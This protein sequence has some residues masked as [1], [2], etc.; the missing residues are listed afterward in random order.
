MFEKVIVID[1]KGHLLGRLAAV[2]AKELLNGQKIVVVR[3]EELNI[4]G[5]LERN[6]RAYAQFV[7]RIS[8]TNPW[9]GGPWHYKNPS[10]IFWRAVRGMLPHKT[11]RGAAALTRLKIFEGIPYPYSHMKRTSVASALR[12]VRLDNLRHF[13]VLKDLSAKVGW[14]KKE[15]I[16]NLEAKRQER[17][18]KYWT[19]K[20]TI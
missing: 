12:C 7:N 16:Q 14:N 6:L 11:P 5:P 2:V 10:K 18:S 1:A 20:V 15:L 13:T 9:R 3:A 8:N 19:D 17:A 4:T